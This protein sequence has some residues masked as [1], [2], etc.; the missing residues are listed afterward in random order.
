M[1]LA[2]PLPLTQESPLGQHPVT[3]S[4]SLSGRRARSLKH[5]DSFAVLD[6]S[7]DLRG[8]TVDGFYHCDTRHL[9]R[10]ELVLEGTRPVLLSSSIRDDNTA[11]ICDL[12]NSELIPD[13]MPDGSTTPIPGESLHIR[14]TQFLWQGTLFERI[15]VRNFSTIHMRIRLSLL[16]EADFADI[17]E[18]RGDVRKRRGQ[19]AP[20][21]LEKQKII[22]R[23]TGLDDAERRTTLHCSPQPSNIV[24]GRIDFD[25]DLPPAAGES[26]FIEVEAS[27]PGVPIA[28]DA[29][30]A[31]VDSRPVRFQRMLRRL[32][33]SARH[34]SGR[35]ASIKTSNEIFNEGMRRSVADLYMLAT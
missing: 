9:S 33:R 6:V 28:S 10:F 2:D 18:V 25:L 22:W 35:A 26:L 14:R 17:F 12:S 13:S 31:D 23:Y 20:V 27:D 11:L 1:V 34:A 16:V 32:R 3:V 29:P 24:E 8:A 15:R 21:Q 7:G 5:D 4:E 30:T 19:F